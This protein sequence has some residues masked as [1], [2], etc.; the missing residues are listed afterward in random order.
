[1]AFKHKTSPPQDAPLKQVTT[2][3]V[4]ENV[5]EKVEDISTFD[6]Q[7]TKKLLRKIDWHLIPFLSLLYL[8]SF[9]DRTNIGNAKLFGLEKSL[10]MKG[11]QYNTALCVF[12]VTYVL[13]EVPSNMI[14]KRWRASMWFP[15]MMLAWGITMTLTGL[16][17]DFKGLVIARVFLGMAESG[18]FPGVNYYITLWY[19]R[20]E[21]A[22]RAAI[23]FSA[24]TVAGAFGGLLARL[25]NEMDGTGG[26]P[27]WAWIFILE[28][29]LTVV[30]AFVAFW[31]MSDNPQTATFLTTEEA[32]EV[33][34]RLKHDNDDLAHHYDTKFMIHAFADW[35]IWLQ[36][37]AYIGILTP[38]YSFSLFLPSII[39]AMGYSDAMSQLLTVPPYV[40]GCIITVLGGYFSDKLNKRGIFLSIFSLTAIVGY[41]LLL[42][43]DIPG[44]QYT[45]TFLAASGVYPAIPIMVMWNGNNIGGSTK[46]GV[47]IAIQIGF[48][49][50]GGVIA[51][52]IYRNQDAPRY[53]LGHGTCLGFLGMSFILILA[54]MAILKFINKRRDKDHPHPSTYTTEMKVAER[55]NGDQASFFRY[56]I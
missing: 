31:A 54:Q 12:F 6:V 44:V 10:N 24:A 56:T 46:R 2:K 30:V 36:S 39:R 14:L 25:I 51:S 11:M 23:F 53:Y 47:G 16:V 42:S 52:F 8:L 27:G 18:L 43:T 33:Y 3:D 37:V 29:L 50:C 1:M 38:L 5:E 41:I 9:L 15:I 21:C 49:N 13:F 28:G 48:G 19:A 34:L 40:L 26:R 45:G 4:E 17:T 55:D 22:F 35:K 32:K 7:Q 20:K